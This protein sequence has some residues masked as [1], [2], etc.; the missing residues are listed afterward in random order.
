[1]AISASR[2]ARQVADGA[3]VPVPEEVRDDVDM[4]RNLTPLFTVWG[5]FE[6]G[7]VIQSDD[8]VGGILPPRQD[9]Q[10]DLALLAQGPGQ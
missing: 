6:H 4:L 10:A 3:G 5:D 8:P 7:T 9:E 2:R 1:M